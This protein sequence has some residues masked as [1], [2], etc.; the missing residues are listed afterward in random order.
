MASN[1][2][3]Q[4]EYEGL[5]ALNYNNF[6]CLYKRFGLFKVAFQYFKKCLDLE[7]QLLANNTFEK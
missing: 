6:G 3:N 2:K 1:L 4:S 7:K 5:L